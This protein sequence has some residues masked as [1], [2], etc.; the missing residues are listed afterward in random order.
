MKL[1]GVL[2]FGSITTMCADGLCLNQELNQH[3][4][5]N[6]SNNINNDI[7]DGINTIMH[8]FVLATFVFLFFVFQ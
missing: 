4:K 1:I 8:D 7:L 6:N 2:C 3:L 5:H